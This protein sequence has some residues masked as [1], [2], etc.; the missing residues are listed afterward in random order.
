MSVISMDTSASSS[1][2]NAPLMLKVPLFGLGK[3]MR[4]SIPVITVLMPVVLSASRHAA[5]VIVLLV[6]QPSGVVKITFAAPDIV[7]L[8]RPEALIVATALVLVLHVPPPV[9]PLYNC[10]V[11][12]VQAVV[13]PVITDNGFTVI[14]ARLIQPDGEV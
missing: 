1:V 14:D 9:V 6:I 11:R 12:P 3:R 5:T 13:E 4:L 2:A 7:A 10:M 8:N